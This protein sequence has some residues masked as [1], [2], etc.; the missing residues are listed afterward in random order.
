LPTLPRSAF[1]LR[2]RTT[3]LTLGDE[4]PPQ[5]F[6]EVGYHEATGFT[7]GG[8]FTSA[9][10]TVACSGGSVVVAKASMSG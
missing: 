2:S 9:D 3:T 8:W 5:P 7:H 1:Q 6:T 10:T 4:D